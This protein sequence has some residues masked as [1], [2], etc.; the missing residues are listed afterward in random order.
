V[1]NQ[2]AAHS[3]ACVAIEADR[4]WCCTGTP[5]NNDI[6]GVRGLGAW[7]PWTALDCAQGCSQRSDAHTHWQFTQP[8]TLPPTPTRTQTYNAHTR[9][10]DL[11]GQF[12][13]LHMQPLATKSFFDAHVKNAFASECFSAGVAGACKGRGVVVTRQPG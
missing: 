7:V 2:N 10:T 1:K 5:I 12:A 4:R 6:T 8:L 13:A 9:T 11:L 3:K